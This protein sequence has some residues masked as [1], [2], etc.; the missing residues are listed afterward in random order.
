MKA[1]TR[2]RSPRR[3][4]ESVFD[5]ANGRMSITEALA[6]AGTDTDGYY[7]G[8]VYCPFGTLYHSDGGAAK[9]MRV[10]ATSNSCYCFAGCGFLNPVKVLAMVH[11]VSEADAAAMI[12]DLTGYVP[13]DYISQWEALTAAPVQMDRE[14][15]AAALH[16]ACARYD[17]LWEDHQFE[18]SVLVALRQCLGLLPKVTT[19]DDATLWLSATK[20]VMH[21]VLGEL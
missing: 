15:L 18:D 8:K 5:L 1:P 3:T 7:G 14:S 17:P 11:D 12:L 2:R 16:V 6:E 20:K 21:R 4:T 9:A 19:P 13:P 10:Y